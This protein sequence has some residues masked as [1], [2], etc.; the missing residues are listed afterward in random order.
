MSDLP[1][2]TAVL[3]LAAEAAGAGRLAPPCS[4][5]TAANPVCGDKTTVDLRVVN[6]HIE[7]VAQDTRAC[8]LTQASASILGKSLA[9]HSTAELAAL[10]QA[11]AAMLSGGPAP[12]GDFAA[13]AVLAEVARHPARHRCVL[14]PID[15]ALKAAEPA[16]ER[17]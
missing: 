2:T 8:V 11:I 16:S 17:S 3:R 7:A 15:A 12:E 4:S 6:D 5:H 1:Y 14:L 10:R 13:Y 9:G